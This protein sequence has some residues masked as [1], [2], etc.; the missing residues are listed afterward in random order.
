MA[1]DPKT[2]TD[3]S[4]RRYGIRVLT[5]GEMLDLL[6]AAGDT[7]STNPGWMRMALAVASVASIDDVPMPPLA[8]KRDIRAAAD[9]IGN[10]GLVALQTALMGGT[11][12]EQ[13]ATD[14]KA[15]AAA[16]N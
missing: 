9:Q 11:P 1:E 16:G 8:S 2:V 13:R 3:A 6:E 4:G 5:P 7:N 12:E 10:A 14:A 15:M